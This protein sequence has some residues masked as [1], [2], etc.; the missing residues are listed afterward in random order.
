M[1]AAGLMPLILSFNDGRLKYLFKSSKLSRIMPFRSSETS[2]GS[3]AVWLGSFH[4]NRRFI[5]VA[6]IRFQGGFVRLVI[7][8][9]PTERYPPSCNCLPRRAI[10]RE[11]GWDIAKTDK[12]SS[13]LWLDTWD[14]ADLSNLRYTKVRLAF[15]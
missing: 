11:L 14:T 13:F 12:E 15:K 3:S 7:V 10:C 1:I 4:P 5:C 9:I 8:H 2:T 6:R